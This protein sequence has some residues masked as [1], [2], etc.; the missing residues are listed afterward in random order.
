MG[1]HLG[2]GVRAALLME[3]VGTSH[4]LSR[5]AEK[6]SH[7]KVLKLHYAGGPNTMKGGHSKT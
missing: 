7:D 2:E 3:N 1:T 4:T 5:H 6:I